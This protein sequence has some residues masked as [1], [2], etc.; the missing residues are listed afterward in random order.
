MGVWEYGV[1]PRATA[2]LA[3][4]YHDLSRSKNYYHERVSMHVK[5]YNYKESTKV[6]YAKRTCYKR[7]LRSL[8]IIIE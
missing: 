1:K 3:F 7:T 4:L 6:L 5:R 8:I 2:F